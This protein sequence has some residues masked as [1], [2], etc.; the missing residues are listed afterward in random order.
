LSLENIFHNLKTNYSSR[1]DDILN[2]V[3]IPCFQNSSRYYRGTAYF[4][5]SVL[6]LYKES[7]LGFCKKNGAKISILTSTEVMPSDAEDIILGY[8]L[9][10]LEL[11]LESLLIDEETSV[12]AKFV[13]AL[14]ASKKL[15]IHVVK[16]PLYHDKVGFFSDD[17]NKCVAFTGSGNETVPGISKDKNFERYVLS[18]SGHVGFSSYGEKWKRELTDAFDHGIYADAEIYRFDELSDYFIERFDIP[19]TTDEIIQLF[20]PDFMYFDYDLLSKNGPQPHQIQA[21]NGWRENSMFGFFEHAT[22]TYKTATGL[23]CADSFLRDLDYVVISTPRKIIS[24]NWGRLIGNCFSKEI[25]LIKCWS[26]YKD[27]HS[28]AINTVNSGRKAI[29]VFVNDTLWSKQ[30]LSFLKILRDEFLLIAD[31]THRWQDSR[32]E[33]FLDIIQP[34]ARLALTAKLSEPGLEA[35]VE[36][37]LDYFA[38]TKD[39]QIY[40]DNLDLSY[41]IREGFLRE[42]HYDLVVLKPKIPLNEFSNPG[43]ISEVWSDFVEQKR[44]YSPH[45]IVEKL[46]DFNR[47]LAYTGPKIDHAVEMLEET[48]RIWLLDNSMTGIFKKVT[49]NEN[50]KSRHRIIKQFNLGNVRSLVA[51]KVLDEG[52]S[53]PISDVAIMTTSTT[54]HRQWIQRRGRV[55]RKENPADDSKAMIVDFILDISSFHDNIRQRFLDTYHSETNRILEFGGLSLSGIDQY[56]H[57][58]RNC[59][60]VV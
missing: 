59:G 51:I 37:L 53:L 22:G 32:S 18:W 60:W 12:A 44:A 50:Q 26:D 33:E 24:E 16:G 49:G 19:T 14:I 1:V 34:K 10:D 11:S 36:H 41:A 43:I 28:E 39:G 25:S 46:N 56:R 20:Q 30:G 8:K 6:E 55:L 9:R 52:V 15:D 45:K 48:Q 17:Q 13:C 31:E 21:F 27:W 29:F 42:Y 2:D 35:D 3:Y 47:V 5:T 58:L 38:V 54:S 7:V 40:Y 23:M 4:R 57:I